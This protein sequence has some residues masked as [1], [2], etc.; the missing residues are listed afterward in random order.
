MGPHSYI[1]G[2]TVFLIVLSAGALV[3]TLLHCV[4]WMRNEQRKQREEFST[5]QLLYSI[6]P[7]TKGKQ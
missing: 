6:S 2:T 3:V 1:D 5:Q 4:A 7:P